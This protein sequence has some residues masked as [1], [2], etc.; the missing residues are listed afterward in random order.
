MYKIML[1]VLPQAVAWLRWLVTGLSLQ[2]PRFEGRTVHERFVVVK[3]EV[4]TG[5]FGPYL[6]A[7]NPTHDLTK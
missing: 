6:S 2:R 1:T 5:F 7:I 3:V 4:G